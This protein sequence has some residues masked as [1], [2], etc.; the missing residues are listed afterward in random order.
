MAK[1]NAAHLFE[2]AEAGPKR[3]T[4]ASKD[5]PAQAG[6]RGKAEG[7]RWEGRRRPRTAAGRAKQSARRTAPA[8]GERR[9][10]PRQDR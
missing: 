3:K 1:V 8:R 9:Q 7:G 5:R 6:G 4:T 10:A 2:T